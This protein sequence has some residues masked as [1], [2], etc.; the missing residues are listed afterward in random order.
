MFVSQY[1]VTAPAVGTSGRPNCIHI[2]H[3]RYTVMRCYG[4][5]CVQVTC[6][7]AYRIQ[8]GMAVA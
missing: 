8:L 5:L 6:V 4:F 2:H 7:I 1:R 3:L